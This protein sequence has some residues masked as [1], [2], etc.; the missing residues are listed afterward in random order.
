[1][2]PRKVVVGAHTYKVR[3]SKIKQLGCCDYDTQVLKLRPGMEPD[4]DKEVLLHEVLHACGY[5]TLCGKDEEFV[6]AIAPVL[7]QVMRDNPQLVEYLTQ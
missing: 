6:D 2:R 7:L 4:K 1:M 5:P 3:L